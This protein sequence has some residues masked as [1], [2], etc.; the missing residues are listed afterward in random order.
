M[1]DVNDFDETNPG[2]FEWD[3]KRLSTSF[4]IA[5][6]QYGFADQ[7][8]EQVVLTSAAAYRVMMARLAGMGELESWYDHIDID[9]AAALLRAQN[10]KEGV[11]G[12]AQ[13][14]QGGRTCSTSRLAAGP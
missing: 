1:F 5:C 8:R 6:R 11:E 10:R 2:P 13:G 14:G 7:D 9:S 4:E 12:L 3:V